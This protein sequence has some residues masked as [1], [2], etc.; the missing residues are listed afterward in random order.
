MRLESGGVIRWAADDPLN[1]IAFG[2]AGEQTAG[3]GGGSGAYDDIFLEHSGQGTEGGQ[4][5][6]IG[7]FDPSLASQRIRLWSMGPVSVPFLSTAYGPIWY[8]KLGAFW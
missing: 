3:I 5:L 4:I 8:A 1:E 7:F 2:L 6:N